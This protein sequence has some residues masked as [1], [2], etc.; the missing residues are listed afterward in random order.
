MDYIAMDKKLEPVV[1]LMLA[2]KPQMALERLQFLIHQGVFLPEE[3]WRVYQ[4]M[5][6]CYFALLEPE[7]TREVLWECLTHPVGMPL[8]KQQE[9]YSNYLFISHYHPLVSDEELREKHFLYNQLMANNVLFHH[10]KRKHAK[11]RIGYLAPMHCRNVVSFFSVHLMT[12][13]DRSRFEVYLYSFEEENDALT[14]QLKEQTDGW[15]VF[16]ASMMRREM[17]EK[18]YQDEIDIL[19]DLGVHTYGGRTLQIM[20]YRPA[21]VQMA[22]IG[23]MSTSGM[24]AIDYFL[25]DRYCDPPG[26]NDEDFT[27]K[28][29]RLPH[30]HFCY[31]PPERIL[32]CKGVYKLH[33]P[34]WFGSFNNIAKINESVLRCWREILRR[35]PGSMLLIKNA[36]HSVWNLTALRQKMRRLGFPDDQ[37]ILEQGSADYLDRYL[38]VDIVLDTYPYT[39]GGSTCD[40]LLRGMPVITRYGKRHGTRFSYS[41]L[42]NVGLEDLAA[43]SDAEYIEKAVALANNPERIKRIHAEL[44]QIMMKSPIMN[45]KDYV[46]T[47]ENVYERIW[48]QWLVRA[49]K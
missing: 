1:K 19:V 3:M 28:L 40:A 32:Y 30:S 16:P 8:R 45:I 43:S 27:E 15:Q 24:T 44:P 35:V 17:A 22:G 13:Y 46:D 26:Q 6:D 7:K 36:S 25:T 41:L 2:K 37:Y 5:G 33:D 31:M 34:V 9:I 12:A 11:L 48:Q 47:V 42:A 38:D 49:G 4:R 29:I 18:I 23:Y 20:G 39:G 21:P 14:V 10:R